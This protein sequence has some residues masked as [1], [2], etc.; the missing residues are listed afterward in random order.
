M[1]YG[2]IANALIYHNEYWAQTRKDAAWV[3]QH[4]APQRR[5]RI[6][7]GLLT[8]SADYIQAQRVRTRLRN[9][10]AAVLD[11]LDCLALPAQNGPAPKV[12]D[13]GPLDVL[14]RHVVPEFQAPFNLTGVPA[15]VLPAG[16][17]ADGLPIALQLVGK[18]FDEATVLRA[19]YAYQ[20]A[21]D[22]HRRRPPI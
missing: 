18:A 10:L 2:T 4:A 20:Q 6:F 14:Y 22:W 19:G 9:E 13:V 5:A 17:S 1:S 7:M 8:G 16:F 3:L 11:D 15:L 12:K 21:T